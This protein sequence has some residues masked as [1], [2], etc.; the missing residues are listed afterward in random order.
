MS[1][2]R[3]FP[4]TARLSARSFRRPGR[5]VPPAA[6]HLRSRSIRL[7]PGGAIDWH[8]TGQREELL[9]GMSG[10]VH[11][12]YGA[13]PRRRVELGPGQCLFLPFATK[14]RVLNTSTRPAQYVYV[15]G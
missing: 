9:L 15:V 5:L 4:Q 1:R 10:T 6:R 12:E 3:L 8:T 2:R 11:I 7:A 14:H 13:D